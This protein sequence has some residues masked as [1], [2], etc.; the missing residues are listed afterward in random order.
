MGVTCPSVDSRLPDHDP[1]FSVEGVGE[2]VW[3]EKGRNLEV[4]PSHQMRDAMNQ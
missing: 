3:V 2:E 1:S 4:R